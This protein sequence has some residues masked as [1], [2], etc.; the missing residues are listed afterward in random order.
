MQS[1]KPDQSSPVALTKAWQEE[2]LQQSRWLYN[3]EKNNHQILSDYSFIVFPAAKAFE[4][5]L[6][7]YLLSMGLISKETHQSKRFRIGRALNPDVPQ[8]QRDVWWLYDDVSHT[9]GE[10]T[11]RHL[12]TTWLECRN[13]VFHFFPGEKSS[14]T[15]ERAAQHLAQI[16]H[17]MELA[18]QCIL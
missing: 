18:T 1:Q 5:F 3:R 17:S 4:G 8:N 15:L 10:E 14:M 11:A 13:H 7:D 6:K 2:M 9:C 16:E 12:W